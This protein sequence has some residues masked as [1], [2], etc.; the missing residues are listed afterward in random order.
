MWFQGREDCGTCYLKKVANGL[1][2]R[3]ALRIVHLFR[4]IFYPLVGVYKLGGDLGFVGHQVG[5][6]EPECFIC[7]DSFLSVFQDYDYYIFDIC[8]IGK[9][10]AKCHVGVNGKCETLWYSGVLYF[11]VGCTE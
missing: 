10:I 9:M 7:L 1:D 2:F 11:F 8:G 6:T 4:H 3:V 5:L